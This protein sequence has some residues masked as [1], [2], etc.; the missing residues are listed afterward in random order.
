M[1]KFE[2]DAR[3]LDC[4]KP[5]LRTKKALAEE[6]FNLLT[7][8]VDNVPARE[9][10]CRFLKHSGFTPQWSEQDGDF[11]ITVQREDSADSD[12]A[13]GKPEK[14]AAEV[15]SPSPQA[16]APGG[17]T[18][19]IASNRIGLG[20]KEL[21]K[22]LLKGY[23]YTLTQLDE[24]PGTLIFMNS[25]VK[26]CLDDSDSLEDLRLLESRGVEILVCGTCLEFIGVRERLGVGR[27]S[28]MYEITSSLHGPAGVI[29]FT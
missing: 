12:A 6:D 3:K 11:L 14:S 24:M 10:V 29:S 2:I 7:V 13:A 22:L 20:E 17:K 26:T 23:L 21:G 27:V 15:T 5:L 28:N 19:L 8:L 1:K 4:P 16:E 9:N 25:G 18:V